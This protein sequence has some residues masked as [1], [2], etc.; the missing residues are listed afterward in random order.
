MFDFNTKLAMVKENI[1]TVA[2]FFYQGKQQEGYRHLVAVIDDLMLIDQAIRNSEQEQ[3]RDA[4]ERLQEM[5]QIALDALDDKDE[6]MLADIFNYEILPM[7][8]EIM[9]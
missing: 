6:I 9:E 2:K 5:L 7:L 4:G 8:D 1:E 3:T